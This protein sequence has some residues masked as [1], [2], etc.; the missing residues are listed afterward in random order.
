MTA[1]GVSPITIAQML[2][3]IVRSSFADADIGFG[4]QGICNRSISSSIVVWYGD[5]SSSADR[6]AFPLAQLGYAIFLALCPCAHS[7][8]FRNRKELSV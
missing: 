4:A 5:R 8:K 3:T 7:G 2:A 1:A 6:R